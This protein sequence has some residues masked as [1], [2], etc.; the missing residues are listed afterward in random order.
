MVSS[1]TLCKKKLSNDFSFAKQIKSLHWNR[2]YVLNIVYVG[3]EFNVKTPSS[4]ET[5]ERDNWHRVF[6]MQCSTLFTSSQR[7]GL[8]GFTFPSP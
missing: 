5:R 7:S 8:L 6:W 3:Q 2:F 4:K 1:T